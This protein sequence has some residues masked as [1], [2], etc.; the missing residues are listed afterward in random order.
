[1]D[2]TLLALLFLSA[3]LISLVAPLATMT[4]AVILLLTA[5]FTWGSWSI[6]QG[7]G[8]PQPEVQRVWN[9]E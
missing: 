7:V 2:R 1:M 8:Q 4:V 3:L 6:M 9:E 5:L